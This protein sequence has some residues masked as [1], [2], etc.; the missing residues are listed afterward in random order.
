MILPPTEANI[1]AAGEAI[2][3]GE[4]VGM[5]TETVYGIA[6]DATS[7]EA[8]ASVFALKGRP[9]DNPLIV[10]IAHLEQLSQVV[11]E[12]TK[13]AE[14][15]IERFWPGPL[16]LVLPRAATVPDA[17]TGGGATVAVRVPAHPVA[18]R[19]ID[20]AERP[21]AAPSANAFMRLSPTRAEDVSPEIGWGLF[22]VLDGGPCAIGIES[23][24]IDLTD[25]P[26]LLRPGGV[27]RA[28]IEA[29]LHRE[30]AAPAGERRSPGM[31]PRH[32]SPK[33]PLRLVG[34]LG[35]GD[36]GLT[37]DEPTGPDQT[38]MPASPAAYAIA[39]YAALHRLEES[40]V[41]EILVQAP[42]Q[43]SEWEAVRD[44]LERA[45]EP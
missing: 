9:A 35:S 42:S 16:T 20:A 41:E 14:R 25:E 38:R 32:Y 4:R 11:K 6:V 18:L 21:L 36:A 22:A 24:V 31:Y 13:D 5:P 10:H 8:V 3:R 12:V 28:Q 17:V 19:L 39:L 29:A 27:P 30:L 2:R 23:T 44:R 33:V 45:S 34:C 7:P 26:R 15:L 40:G 43:S 1:R 37:F